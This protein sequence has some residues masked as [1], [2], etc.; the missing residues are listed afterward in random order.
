MARED[1]L[2]WP[3]LDD[4]TSAA[5]AFLDPVLACDLDATWDPDTW[6]WTLP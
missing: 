4:V 3:T 1:Q 6:A 2:V 5:K